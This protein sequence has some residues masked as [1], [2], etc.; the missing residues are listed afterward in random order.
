MLAVGGKD[1]DANVVVVGSLV[2]RIVEVVQECRVLRIRRLWP[3]QNNSG[4]AGFGDFIDDVRWF[5]CRHRILNFLVWVPTS[6]LARMTTSE[7]IDTAKIASA[8]GRDIPWLVDQQARRRPDKVFMVWEPFAT[9]GEAGAPADGH[10]AYTYQE[11][12]DAVDRFAS[13]LHKRGARF[14]DR[15]LVHLDNSPEFVIAWFACAK[16]GAVAVSTNTRSVERDMTY[17]AEHAQVVGAITSPGFA[18]LVHDSA[19]HIQFL[20]VTET[21]AG[22]PATVPEGIAYLPFKAVASETTPCPARA[23]DHM[24]DIGIQFTSGTTSRPKAVL[25][26]HAN[27][28][29]GAQINASHMRITEEDTTLVFLPL[30]HTNA[31][32]YSMLATMY[33]GGTMVLQPKFSAS[34]FW[35]VSLRNRVTWASVIPF[36]VK[37]I[38]DQPL[39]EEHHYRFWGAGARM[40]SVESALGIKTLSWWGM[41]ETIT[42]GIIGSFDH[43]DPHLS[44]GRAAPEFDISVRAADGTPTPPGQRGALFIRGIR[45]VSLFKEYYRNPEAN[46]ESFDADGWFATGDLIHIDESGAMFFSDREKDMLKVGAENI[47][48]SEIEAVIME[49]GWVAEC[50]VV[51]QKHFMLDEVPVVFVIGRPA[52]P[53]DLAGELIEYCKSQLPDFKV[54]RSVHIVDELPRSTL[55]K[56]A[57]NELRARLPEITA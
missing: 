57:K 38:F 41:T 31:Q 46:S 39:P 29:F 10:A 53:E 36:C 56:V 17:F 24:A 20:I 3:I 12:A 49:T 48:A 6:K 15:I 37:A 14:G 5:G 13:G 30:F 52:A 42:H 45:G 2:E 54:V 21:D 28:F 40:E 47:A 19:P 27:A 23:T 51:G 35:P 8:T 4:D 22:T 7:S 32:A 16:L 50:A 25:W 1:D 26:T 44:I 33:S 34:R 55:E 18:Q 11:F 43:P 9:T